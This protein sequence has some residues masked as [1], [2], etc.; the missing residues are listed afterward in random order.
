[1]MDAHNI[2]VPEPK[3]SGKGRILAWSCGGCAVVGIL[4]VIAL[5]LGANSF[6]QWG[7]TQDLED[8]RV[9]VE[10][11]SLPAAEKDRLVK[12]IDRVKAKADQGKLPGFIR[13]VDLT[14]RIDEL[15]DDGDVTA[16]DAKVMHEVFDAIEKEQL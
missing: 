16:S 12:R 1:M 13:W 4:L 2:P 11:G 10:G 14:T 6:Y 15:V 3:G 9:A 8:Y 7:V 5:V